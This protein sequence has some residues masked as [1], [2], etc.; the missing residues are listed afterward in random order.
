MTILLTHT[1]MIIIRSM[2]K[3]AISIIVGDLSRFSR[4][5]S[6]L[7][8]ETSYLTNLIKT[9]RINVERRKC[10][11]YFSFQNPANCNNLKC[12]GS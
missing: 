12:G 10:P 5:L 4:E 8:S 6:R 11:G 3:Y 9:K 2:A 7:K 1:R